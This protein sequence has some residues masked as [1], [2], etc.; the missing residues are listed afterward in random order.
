MNKLTLIIFLVL[1]RRDT[2]MPPTLP[3]SKP[4]VNALK[5]DGEGGRTARLAMQAQGKP[6]C[7]CSLEPGRGSGVVCRPAHG[8][9]W[10]S[11]T[12][13]LNRRRSVSAG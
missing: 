3:P 5:R 2:V 13:D 1:Y 8:L 6:Q 7:L 9:T 4:R 11:S 12:T 10:S